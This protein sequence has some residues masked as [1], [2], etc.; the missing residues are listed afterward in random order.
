[1]K[2]IKKGFFSNKMY[3]KRF[4]LSKYLGVDKFSGTSLWTYD[5][6]GYGFG[7]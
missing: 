7:E 3:F 5:F 6:R 4:T 1:M 2:S